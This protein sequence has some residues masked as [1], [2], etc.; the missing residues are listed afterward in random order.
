MEEGEGDRECEKECDSRLIQLEERKFTPLPPCPSPDLIL[1]LWSALT[2][3][4][5]SD[6]CISAKRSHARPRP[7]AVV[8]LSMLFGRRE[9]KE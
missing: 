5:C 6:F 1:L 4:L 9:E 8:T 3:D 7:Q 2:N